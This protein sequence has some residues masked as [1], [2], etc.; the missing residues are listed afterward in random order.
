M[1]EIA[2]GQ[3]ISKGLLVSLNPPKKRTNEFVFTGKSLSEALI[4]ALTNPQYDDRL[5]I[6][7]PVEYIKIPSSEHVVYIN[8]SECLNKNKKQQFV[9]TTSSEL[10]IFMYSTGN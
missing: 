4:L 3:I 6:E 8:Y 7:L 10:G 2:K 1:C 9:Y 5:F